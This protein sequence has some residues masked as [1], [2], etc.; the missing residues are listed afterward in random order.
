[1]FILSKISGVKC[2][3]TINYK[4]AKIKERTHSRQNPPL[5]F[6]PSFSEMA[7]RLE[8][9]RFRGVY[10]QEFLFALQLSTQN[11]YTIS[12]EKIKINLSPEQYG[13]L[14]VDAQ[15]FGF[16]KKG[17]E[18]ANLNAFLNTL[19][20]NAYHAR[21][22]KERLIHDHLYQSFKALSPS[23]QALGEMM[24]YINSVLY[25]GY[26]SRD[27]KE[28]RSFISLRPN[29]EQA[30]LFATIEAEE[31][32]FSNETMSGYLRSLIDDY[33]RLSGAE[34][35]SLLFPK[36]E[37]QILDALKSS[38]KLR[39]K[40][41]T[42]DFV[43]KPYF[44]DSNDEGTFNY[45]YGEIGN[46]YNP[47]PRSFH[48]FKLKDSL[49]V[50]PEYFAFTPEDQ[51]FLEN[52]LKQ[53]GIAYAGDETIDAFVTFDR[54][55]FKML[56]SIYYL[57]PSFVVIEKTNSEHVRVRLHGSSMNLHHYLSRFGEHA[58]VESPLRLRNDLASFYHKA[59]HRYSR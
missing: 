17:T 32:A 50:L 56:K 21:Y 1:M 13:K 9:H 59:D 6:T 57:R 38:R 34:K 55:G 33:L 4:V 3:R 31:L 10:F 45:V 18:E 14:S 2:F 46:G 25:E 19:I 5:F 44:F 58:L 35:E 43:L 22:E 27:E 37:E 41:D 23:D 36:E 12:V 30:T 24:D 47:F 28:L 11:G 39:I 26:L 51:E 20:A 8:T 49:S 16:L 52:K 7:T 29:Q 42:M 48:L 53:D 15:T 54:L 40:N